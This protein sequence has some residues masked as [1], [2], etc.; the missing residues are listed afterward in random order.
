MA[1]K[2]IDFSS[3]RISLKDISESRI[4]SQ[5]SQSPLYK[6]LLAAFTDEIQELL[7][8]IVDLMEYRTIAKAAG[9]NLDTI[10]RIVGQGRESYDYEAAYWFTPDEEGLGVDNGHWWLQGT[11]KAISSLMDD[12]TY[13]KWIWMRVLENHNKFSSKPEVEKAIYEALGETVGI[14]ISNMMT[15]KIYASNTISLTNY[16]LLDYHID[17]YLTDNDYMFAYPATTSVSQKVKV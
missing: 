7:G 11:P 1:S 8:A 4:L 5:Y 2:T 9:K 12:E 15:A 6:K 10:G 17:T 16:A 14:E 3:L 13:R